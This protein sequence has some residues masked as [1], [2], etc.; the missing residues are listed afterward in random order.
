MRFASRFR[1]SILTLQACVAFA[2]PFSNQAIAENPRNNAAS[3]DRS[4]IQPLIE[5]EIEDDYEP[6]EADSAQS[7]VQKA[8]DLISMPLPQNSGVEEAIE[9]PWLYRAKFLKTESQRKHEKFERLTRSLNR[10]DQSRSTRPGQNRNLRDS[11]LIRTQ[12]EPDSISEVPLYEDVPVTLGDESPFSSVVFDPPI[13]YSGPDPVTDHDVELRD[14]PRVPEPMVFDLVRGLGARKGELEFNVLNIV[15]FQRGKSKYEWAPEIEFVPFD[16]F[17]IEYEMPIFNSEIVAHK[18]GLQYTFGTA[19]DNA[20][21]H[22]VQHISYIDVQNPQYIPTFLYLTGLRLDKT[23]SLF[24]MY[25][26]SVGPQAFPFVDEESPYGLNILVNLSIFANVTEKLVLGL[27]TNFDRQVGG[28]MQTLIMPQA[29]VHF[30]ER[31]KA[32]VGFGLRDEVT[33]RFG[34]LGFRVIFER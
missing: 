27:E 31:I 28:P 14:G 17:G 29:H 23:W 1:R 3:I 30:S 34:E 5:A 16:G 12:L 15:P 25:G 7:G 24:G 13:D 11:N 32:Q 22:G 10:S 9:I 21:I 4:L 19:L 26:F 6:F 18:I 2:G 20:F 33:S 8:L